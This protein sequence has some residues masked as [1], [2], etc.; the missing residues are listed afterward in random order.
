[1]SS[2]WPWRSPRRSHFVALLDQ[3]RRHRTLERK[4]RR[5]LETACRQE[6][7][8]LGIRPFGL[9]MK[10]ARAEGAQPIDQ[11]PQQPAPDPAL[12]ALRRDADRIEH[13]GDLLASELAAQHARECEAAQDA[14]LLHTEMDE[15]LRVRRRGREALFEEVAADAA[16]T[17]AIDRDHAVE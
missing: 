14:A 13:R 16:R 5:E 2:S 12:T 10:R 4:A 11:L 1:M 8:Q 6:A 3:R 7:R 9:R 17:G 15:V